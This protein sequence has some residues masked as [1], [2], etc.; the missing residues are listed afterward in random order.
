MGEFKKRRWEKRPKENK[1]NG[2]RR[3]N[4][5]ILPHQTSEGKFGQQRKG[6][7]D[8]K[9]TIGVVRGI[10]SFSRMGEEKILP[11]KIRGRGGQVDVEKVDWV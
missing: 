3:R 10:D 6:M 4:F 9:K 8:W 7:W 11:K 1:F 5:N 2:G